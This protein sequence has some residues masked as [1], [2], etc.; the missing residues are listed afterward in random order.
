MERKSPPGIPATR[1]SLR[2]LQVRV[3]RDT[4]R[5]V[6]AAARRVDQP[7]SAWLRMAIIEKLNRDGAP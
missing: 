6:A 2:L 1:E 4:A 3:Q 7:V 5:K